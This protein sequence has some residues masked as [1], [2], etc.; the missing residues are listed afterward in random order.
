MSVCCP[1]IADDGHV[2]TDSCCSPYTLKLFEF[3]SADQNNSPSSLAAPV[4]QPNFFRRFV[5]L[6]KLYKGRKSQDFIAYG[7][8]VATSRKSVFQLA[9]Q[10]QGV[11]L[12][13]PGGERRR[14]RMALSG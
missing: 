14:H 5:V 12:A 9:P 11:K 13:K 1:A 10:D 4:S 6:V 8:A 2:H 3:K 7:F